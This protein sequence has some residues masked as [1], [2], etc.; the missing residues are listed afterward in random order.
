MLTQDLMECHFV[1]ALNAEWVPRGPASGLK[2]CLLGFKADS[3]V[4]GDRIRSESG[5]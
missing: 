5:L 3:H 4:A 2:K 1:A